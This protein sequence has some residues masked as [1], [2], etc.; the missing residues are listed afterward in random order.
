[1]KFKLRSGNKT[2]F[3]MIGSSPAKQSYPSSAQF[4]PYGPR[5]TIKEVS[6]EAAKQ[7]GENKALK[8]LK[9]VTKRGAK[10]LGG[11]TMGVLSMMT[12][13]SATATQPGTGTHGGKKVGKITDMMKNSPAKE[14][15][16]KESDK[17]FIAR[18]KRQKKEAINNLVKKAESG[19]LSGQAA[20][21][22]AK[23]Q[24]NKNI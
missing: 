11:K 20:I 3:K 15:T 2:P 9:K 10:F 16:K 14:K 23:K 13:P 8:N 7:V 22:A 6:K 19:G 1:M 4:G 17:A 21:D 12:A 18:A 24:Y 5:G